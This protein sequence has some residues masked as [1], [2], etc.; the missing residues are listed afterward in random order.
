MQLWFDPSQGNPNEAVARL[1]AEW[2]TAGSGVG[3]I[4]APPAAACL[5]LL[6]TL[7]GAARR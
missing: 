7:A 6:A 1:Q 2:L 3:P 5:L 4:A